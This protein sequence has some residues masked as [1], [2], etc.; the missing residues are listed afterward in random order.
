MELLACGKNLAYKNP[1][2]LLDNSQIKINFS[3]KI[4][5]LKIY[6]YLCSP[7]LS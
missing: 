7:K 4:L 6:P 3:E 5:Y 1:P 2:Q